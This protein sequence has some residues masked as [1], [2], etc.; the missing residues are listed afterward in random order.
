MYGTVDGAEGD[1]CLM[2]AIPGRGRR[3]GLHLGLRSHV[4]ARLNR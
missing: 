1:S 4:F 2:L 3:D